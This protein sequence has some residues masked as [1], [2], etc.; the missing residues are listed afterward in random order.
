MH[1][2]IYS[3]N[4]TGS[5]TIPY[6]IPPFTPHCQIFHYMDTMIG[7]TIPMNERDFTLPDADYTRVRCIGTIQTLYMCFFFPPSIYPTAGRSAHTV[8]IIHSFA[9][10]TC[11]KCDE[12]SFRLRP[13]SEPDV[14]PYLQY[15]RVQFFS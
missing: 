8:H 3:S 13:P 6:G 11:G 2:S 5:K 15:E 10:I 7:L 4:N 14:F 12:K 9:L 1:L